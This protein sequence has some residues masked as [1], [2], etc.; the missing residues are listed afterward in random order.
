MSDRGKL[1]WARHRGQVSGTCG[2]GV[3][4]PCLAAGR[5]MT[6][7]GWGAREGRRLSLSAQAG[8]QSIS[9]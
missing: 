6:G 4:G 1:R 5:G 9:D 8:S 3:G 2:G 7:W